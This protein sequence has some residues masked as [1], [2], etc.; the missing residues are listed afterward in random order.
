VLGPCNFGACKKRTPRRPLDQRA[1]S[2]LQPPELPAFCKIKTIKVRQ[3]IAVCD[4]YAQQEAAGADE[5][6]ARAGSFLPKTNSSPLPARA[7]PPRNCIFCLAPF[8]ADSRKKRR[9]PAQKSAARFLAKNNISIVH[10][11]DKKMSNLEST[12]L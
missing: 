10:F 7:P 1:I 11:L 8:H 9:A 4:Y 6:W 12:I 5:K 3:L 2:P